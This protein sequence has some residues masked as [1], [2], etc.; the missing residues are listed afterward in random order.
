MREKVALI[1][2]IRAIESVPRI[3]C[4][5][6]KRQFHR[7]NLILNSRDGCRGDVEVTGVFFNYLKYLSV[8]IF[9]MTFVCLFIY[10]CRVHCTLDKT[11]NVQYKM[12]IFLS[13]SFHSFHLS[14]ATSCPRGVYGSDTVFL[15]ILFHYFILPAEL[16]M[17][18]FLLFCFQQVDLTE[19]SGIGLL[20]EMSVAEVLLFKYLI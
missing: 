3:R 13:N 15:T 5:V 1:A 4:K 2:K 17:H 10:I 14:T 8:L 18:F 16:Y 6:R 7:I 19:T 20:G 9:K 12:S 11:Q